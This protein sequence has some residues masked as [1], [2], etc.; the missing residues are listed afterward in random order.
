VNTL[1]FA[2]QDAVR[3][4]AVIEQKVRTG[5]GATAPVPYAVLRPGD[6]M[7]STAPL[8]AD[9]VRSLGADRRP[10]LF[11]FVFSLPGP[12]S[13]E[14]RA[15]I[16]R[17]GIGGHVGSLLYSAHVSK[18]V[19]GEV[20]I[21]NHRLLGIPKF[22]GD[23]AAAARMNAV[24]ELVKRVDRLARTHWYIGSIMVRTP[25]IFRVAPQDG[26]ALVVLNTLPRIT[27]MGLDTEIDAAEFLQIAAAI[28][29]I[30]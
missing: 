12:R 29:A 1:V 15:R 25:R 28:E 10:A 21:E 5:I 16:D 14:L 3:I 30:L 27:A 2:S 18:S 20:T 8:L 17:D 6:P 23:P 26:G 13:V 4:G 9:I 7:P 24:G 11:T 19:A 22:V